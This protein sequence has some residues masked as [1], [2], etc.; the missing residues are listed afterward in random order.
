MKKFVSLMLALAMILVFATACN[1]QS[2]TTTQ[3]TGATSITTGSETASPTTQGKPLKIA[4]AF[5][6]VSNSELAQKAYLETYI[7]PAFNVEFMFSETL[8]DTDAMI[9]FM[10]NAAASGCE[11]IMN[12]QSDATEQAAAKA[13]ELGMY[14]ITNTN[15]IPESVASLPHNMGCIGTSVPTTASLFSEVVEYLIA[16]GKPHNVLIV[17]GG[18]SLGNNQHRESTIAILQTLQE[19]YNLTY[20]KEIK[21]IATSKVETE[22]STGTDMKILI[23]PGYAGSD[24]YIPSLSAILQRGEYD[25]VLST[26]N[27]FTQF[28][29]AVDEVERAYNINIKQASIAAI[30]DATKNS[31]T[32]LDVMGNPSLDA[33]VIKP[34]AVL[35]GG[36]FTILYNALNGHADEIRKDGKASQYHMTNW[37]VRGA[38]GYATVEKLDVKPETYALKVADIQKLLVSNVATLNYDQIYNAFTSIDADSIAQASGLK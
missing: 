38:D 27:V 28:S 19:S 12:F 17:S 16:D 1:T 8:K 34:N 36:M 21:D 31:F 20:D 3:P 13:E 25:I 4:V 15:T 22:V 9:T 11:A 6:N 7:G 24:T 30:G 10:E 18:A 33:A 29:V 2:P 5:A 23:F 35:V 14:I 32:T 26:Y 37:V